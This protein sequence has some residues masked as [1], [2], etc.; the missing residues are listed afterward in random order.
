[1]DTF[2][3]QYCQASS[4][5]RATHGTEQARGRNGIHDFDFRHIGQRVAP[6]EHDKYPHYHGEHRGQQHLRQIGIADRNAT[7]QA[8][9]YEQHE[10]DELID[11]IWNCQSAIDG[12]N[13]HTTNQKTECRG[14]QLIQ[15]E[16]QEIGPKIHVVIP[17]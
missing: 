14:L 8:D 13:D 7:A 1:M 17:P 3:F 15:E 11:R 9:F 2:R 4:E 10:D 6:Y 12:G 16:R 5:G